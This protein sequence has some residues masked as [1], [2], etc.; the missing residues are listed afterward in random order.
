M[1]V[2]RYQDVFSKTDKSSNKVVYE[3]VINPKMI[4]TLDDTIYQ[5]KAGDRLDLLA[6]KFYNDPTLWVIIFQA[7]K[8]RGLKKGSLYVPSGIK[9]RIPADV[10]T[11]FNNLVNINV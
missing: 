8:D 4:F 5:S 3:T 1:A 10:G 11:F 2:D 9:L 6:Y 7:N